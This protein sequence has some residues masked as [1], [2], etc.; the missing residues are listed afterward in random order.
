MEENCFHVYASCISIVGTSIIFVDSSKESER[1]Y[2]EE[3]STCNLH[4]IFCQL[5]CLRGRHVDSL[6]SNSIFLLTLTNVVKMFGLIETFLRVL[7]RF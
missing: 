5:S 1:F 2:I 6:M 3:K 7:V 4:G